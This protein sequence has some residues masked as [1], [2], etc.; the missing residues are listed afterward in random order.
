[1]GLIFFLV[2]F[3]FSSPSIELFYRWASLGFL[4]FSGL[5]IGEIL[6]KKKSTDSSLFFFRRGLQIFWIFLCLNCLNFLSI[7]S[8]DATEFLSFYESLRQISLSLL[9]GDFLFVGAL[10]LPLS[11]LL[12]LLPLLKHLPVTI[13]F[14]WS[15]LGFFV[16]DILAFEKDVFSLNGIYLLMGIIG[17]FSGKFFS[18]EKVRE[19]INKK[20]VLLPFFF[21]YLAFGVLFL[22]GGAENLPLFS[23]SS[24]FIFFSQFFSSFLTAWSFHFLLFLLFFFSLP[25]FLFDDSRNAKIPSRKFFETLGV[26]MLFVYIFIAFLSEGIHYFFPSFVNISSLESFLLAFHL[27]FFVFFVILL[28]KKISRKSKIFKKI[29][30]FWF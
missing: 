23:Q 30:R 29:F 19:Q 24:F 28:I 13:G 4:F 18:L 21:L 16:L 6:C 22:G 2:F 9:S 7:L 12:L 1:M 27:T 17:F 11:I 10:L 3:E 14:F 5:I 25:S 8:H 26:E 20:F 15:I